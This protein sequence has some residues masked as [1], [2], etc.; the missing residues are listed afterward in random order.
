MVDFAA[1]WPK[2]PLFTKRIIRD[3]TYIRTIADAVDQ[4]N[5]EPDATVARLKA[6]ETTERTAGMSA[7]VN[8]VNLVGNPVPTEIGRTQTADRLRTLRI[9]TSETW[10]DK[11]TGERKEKTE[12][13]Y[14]R[15]FL[16]RSAR[17]P[18]KYL[19]KDR[20]FTL[21]AH[22]NAQMDRQGR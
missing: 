8:K 14:R 6:M 22:P 12:R 1:Y 16:N 3:D 7:S 2:L 5:D 9:A 11:S 19:C 17:L 4:F 21:R 18:S 20:R 13:A 10:R 15:H